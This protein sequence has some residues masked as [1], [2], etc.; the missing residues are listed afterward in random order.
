[1]TEKLKPCPSCGCPDVY[2][3][4]SAQAAASWIEC[5]LCD[6]RVQASVAEETLAEQWNAIDRTAMPEF[7]DD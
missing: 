5:A 3:D 4:S 1:M 2:L 6:N 7:T